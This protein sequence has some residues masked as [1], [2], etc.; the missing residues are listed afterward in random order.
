MNTQQIITR[1]GVQYLATIGPDGIAWCNVI[2]RRGVATKAY[3]L[4]RVINGT[5]QNLG[6]MRREP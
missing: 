2:G 5:I 3:R 4:G 1:D 6:P